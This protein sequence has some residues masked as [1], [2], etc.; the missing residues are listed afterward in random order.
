MTLVMPLHVSLAQKVARSRMVPPFVHVDKVGPDDPD[1]EGVVYNMSGGFI[2]HSHETASEALILQVA[3]ASETDWLNAPF[4]NNKNNGGVKNKEGL[5]NWIAHVLNEP[6]FSS[7]EKDKSELWILHDEKSESDAVKLTAGLI[8]PPVR[9]E[10]QGSRFQGMLSVNESNL[11]LVIPVYLWLDYGMDGIGAL[12]D[13]YENRNMRARVPAD[14]E[15]IFE[16]LVNDE[17]KSEY[18]KR[19]WNGFETYLRQRGLSVS[20]PR[21]EPNGDT[22]FPDWSA[23]IE[24][25]GKCDVEIT[26]MADGLIKPRLMQFGRDPL[27]PEHDPRIVRAMSNAKFGERALRSAV[28]DA[29]TKKAAKKPE[30]QTGHEY[31]LI[32]V[33]DIF[34]ILEP[35]FR[36][37]DG[38]D[39]SGF[40]YVF[41]AK[42]DFKT[43][44][45]DFHLIHPDPQSKS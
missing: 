13:N 14:W 43:N 33:N 4:A 22:T 7:L 18:E 16:Y 40:D 42:R 35:W 1:F 3:I 34:P 6:E 39:Y 44:E 32:V 10:Y 17:E 8:Q 21:Q 24:L 9:R 12:I 2:R 11:N 36:I 37:W 23:S 19:V 28:S 30:V 38:H 41:L 31:V 26:R 45:Y 20:E 15:P 27:N 29:L 25:I 5:K